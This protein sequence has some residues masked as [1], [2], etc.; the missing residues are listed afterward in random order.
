MP[1]RLITRPFVLV[2][3]AHLLQGMAF[4]L[5][6]HLPRF[7]DD[8][9]A[10]ESEIGILFAI[11][12]ATAILIRPAIGTA[13]DR[14]GRR[15]VIIVANLLNV[16]VIAL[17]LT[18]TTLGPWIYSIRIAHG[19]TEAMLFT[20]LF[21]AGI[22]HIPASRRA[23]GIALFGVSGLL[24]IALAGALGDFVL[25]AS[26]FDALFLT[27]EA[28]AIGS[29]L[30]ALPLRDAPSA[31]STTQPAP[32]MRTLLDPAL[33]PLWWITFVFSGALTAYFVF[34]RTFIDIVGFGSVGGFFGAYA[35]TAIAVRIIGGGLPDRLGATTVLYPTLGFLAIG[36]IV[37]ATADSATAIL[38]AGVLSGLGHG[39]GFPILLT[40]VVTAT[41]HEARGSSMAIFSGLFDAATL[42]FAPILGVV[43]DTLGYTEMFTMSAVW[44]VI[45]TAIFLRWH[46]VRGRTSAAG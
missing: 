38:A 3:L 35:V 12:A 8:L 16:V 15:P 34:L 44:L 37:L 6:V 32:F 10:S 24:P 21:T 22:D 43:I 30:L 20:A 4:F 36:L 45:G 41:P 5:F 33:R 26:G 7:L 28:L 14:R 18:V 23:Q 46:H 2:S 29:L 39:Y 11:T 27:A 42:T 13:I 1:E 17:Y 40:L 9:G 31:R 25:D 19:L